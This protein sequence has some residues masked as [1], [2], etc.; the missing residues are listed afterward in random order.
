MQT[1][2]KQRYAPTFQ[3]LGV[4]PQGSDSAFLSPD[5]TVSDPLLKSGYL[6][7]M[8]GT[9][10][11]DPLITSCNGATPLTSYYLFADPV[12]PG[13]TGNTFYATNTDRIVYSD[14]ESF[15]DRMPETGA[16]ERGTEEK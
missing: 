12:S 10:E 1:C 15:K 5:L 4:P 2:G 13:V 3:N 9:P 7:T 14:T 8:G 11:E 6:F 16:P